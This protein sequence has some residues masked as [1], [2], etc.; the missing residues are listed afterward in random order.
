MD[1]AVLLQ[2]HSKS[3]NEHTAQ[4]CS[5]NVRPTLVASPFPSALALMF[6]LQ[7]NFLSKL[8]ATPMSGAGTSCITLREVHDVPLHIVRCFSTGYAFDLLVGHS[9]SLL[10]NSRSV[11]ASSPLSAKLQKSRGPVAAFKS[12]PSLLSC[13]HKSVLLAPTSLFWACS[14]SY[15]RPPLV[16]RKYALRGRSSRFAHITG[17]GLHTQRCLCVR[18]WRRNNSF[19]QKVPSD[20]ARLWRTRSNSSFNRFARQAP[21]YLSTSSPHLF[22]PLPRVWP[23]R[24][25][26]AFIEPSAHTSLRGDFPSWLLCINFTLKDVI[27]RCKE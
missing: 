3:Q 22:R 15:H 21:T 4:P 27:R 24:T 14:F 18:R 10:H 20:H 13:S 12:L 9:S 2:T 8:R 23:Q 7:P 6:P 19:L 11:P 17:M 25:P 5:Q 1:I 26:S 16:P